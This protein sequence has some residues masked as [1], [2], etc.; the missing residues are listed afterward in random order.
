MLKHF[1]Q[2]LLNIFYPIVKPILPFE[3]YAY[4]A[5]GG[6]NTIL[7][8][9]L[10]A[11]LYLLMADFSLA[12]EVATLLSFCI[13]VVTGFW[14]N[15]QFA[16]TNADQSEHA[17]KQ[18]FMKYGFVALQ[19][20]ISSYILTKLMVLMLAWNPTVAYVITAVIILTVNYFLQR[21]FTFKKQKAIS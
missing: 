12:V 9:G 15:R 21:Y 5:V 4:L 18:Q 7:N 13:T 2:Q 10:F 3:V 6:A 16:F 11:A 14:L 1:I 17:L 8:I 20:Q 19:G